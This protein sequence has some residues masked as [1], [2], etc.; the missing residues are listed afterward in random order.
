M[1]ADFGPCSDWPVYTACDLTG[2]TPVATGYAVKAATRI[3][4]AL[5]GRQFG[6][7]PVTLRPCRR[8]QYA[9]WPYGGWQMWSGPG[10]YSTADWGD[11]LWYPLGCSGCGGECS[12]AV[13]S[14]TELPGPVDSVSKV[15]VNGIVLSPTQYRVDD[16]RWLVRTDGQPW[17]RF[18]DLS[19]PDTETGTWSVT[20]SVGQPV[21][22]SGVLAAGELTCE[23]L[24]AMS[25]EDCR[26]PA[27]V[28]QLVRQGVTISLPDF[29]SML[30]HGKTG[31]YLTDMFLAAENPRRLRQRGRVYSIDHP[32]P[33]RTNT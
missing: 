10:V 1:T 12:C 31:L 28:T 25:G 8:D 5:S 11:R 27:G 3:L 16:N 21:P 20:L 30:E 29:G 7:C 9:A 22:Q 26:L 18:N 17:P 14:E 6:T 15:V 24:R 19:K 13:L 23:I 32:R 4:W 2:Y 33:R